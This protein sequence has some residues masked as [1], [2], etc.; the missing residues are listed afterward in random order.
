MRPAQSIALA[1][2]AEQIPIYN[3][4]MANIRE[5]LSKQEAVDENL[6][7]YAA[8]IA[9]EYE[10]AEEI[11]SF[12]PQTELKNYGDVSKVPVLPVRKSDKIYVKKHTSSQRP[13]FHSQTFYEMICVLRGKTECMFGF[14]N[15][16]AVK[17]EVIVVKPET[18]H[19]L[20]R[21][22]P[23]DV[24]VKIVVPQNIFSESD[25][26]L[27]HGAPF[28]KHRLSAAAEFYLYR[29]LKECVIDDARSEN[30]K[31]MLTALFMTELVRNEAP[32]SKADLTELL[33]EYFET[34]SNPELSEFSVLCG[35]SREHLGR[36]IKRYTGKTFSEHLLDFRA[37]RAKSLLTDTS[38]GID[39]I[40][41]LTG[42][43][44]RA[45]LWKN[46]TNKF[47]VSPNT[48]RNSVK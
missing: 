34:S 20:A 45:G 39:E 37:E 48:Y 26:D 7:D 14:C 28:A 31:K 12:A 6:S 18:V 13:Y 32:A 22:A 36:M 30:V 33:F 10:N 43:K 5:I 3:Y 19:A 40:V 46:F 44:T 25:T 15:E 9:E 8:L 17:G 23:G 24:V 27:T 35:Y 42:F 47:G 21:I 2:E 29:L 1:L 4:R 16:K 41:R 11:L 38:L